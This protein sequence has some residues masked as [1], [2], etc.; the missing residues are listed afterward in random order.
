[1]CRGVIF[2]ETFGPP[3]V[4]LALLVRAG[5]RRT[6][7]VLDCSLRVRPAAARTRRWGIGV[8]SWFETTQPGH[9][10][11]VTSTWINSCNSHAVN[12]LPSF[13]SIDANVTRLRSVGL[14]VAITFE[15]RVD[16]VIVYPVLTVY[17]RQSM[18]VA[19]EAG[20]ASIELSSFNFPSVVSTHRAY[21][22][23]RDGP[24]WMPSRSFSFGRKYYPPLRVPSDSTV[25][26]KEGLADCC[27]HTYRHSM[28]EDPSV[29]HPH[30]LDQ[31]PGTFPAGR[32]SNVLGSSRVGI[33]RRVLCR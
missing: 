21:F 9:L 5:A 16:L 27:P 23:C 4:A 13:I 8:R 19:K 7:I 18:A 2:H 29:S 3:D 15:Q 17:E 20:V 25:R 24:T 12:D 28:P 11:H 1:M 32:R 30:S 26:I 22:Q 14:L 10:V 33:R 31:R 6:L